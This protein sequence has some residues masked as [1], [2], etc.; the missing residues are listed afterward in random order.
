MGNFEK[1]IQRL[2]QWFDRIAQAALA[3][4]MFVVVANILSRALVQSIPGTYEIAGYL[5]AVTIGFALAFCATKG[6]FV[7]VTIA[8]ERLPQRAQAF[9][10]S[11]VDILSFGL[12]LVASW[13]CARL[14]TDLWQAGELSPT[15]KFPFYPLIYATAVCCLLVSLVLLVNVFKSIAQVVRK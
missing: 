13:Y 7:A 5:G 8:V 1:I 4:M 2:S 6:R 3:L 10:S 12:F 9:I 11:I 15:L 14:A